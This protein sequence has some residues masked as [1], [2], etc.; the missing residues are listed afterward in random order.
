[1]CLCLSLSLSLARSLSPERFL[2]LPSLLLFSSPPP[3]PWHAHTLRPSP[4]RVLWL[5]TQIGV[6]WQRITGI[7]HLSSPAPH[8]VSRHPSA[9]H[10]LFTRTP[11]APPRACLA[12]ASQGC[13]ATS[14]PREGILAMPSRGHPREASMPP[15]DASEASMRGI[16]ARH[17]CP[18]PPSH[19]CPRPPLHRCPR[20]RIDALARMPCEASEGIDA[21]RMPH[22]SCLVNVLTAFALFAGGAFSAT[23]CSM[24]P[25]VRRRSRSFGA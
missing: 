17:R 12:H 6:A 5:T 3:P 8:A 2:H 18:R 13:L 24:S 20:P 19:R 16:D 4:S 9:C 14:R 22:A 11:F 15:S 23:R 21:S 7:A 25:G 10:T 1:V